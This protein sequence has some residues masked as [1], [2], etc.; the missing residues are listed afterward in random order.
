KYRLYTR[1][2]SLSPQS[3]GN[4]APQLV[5]L[6]SIWDPLDDSGSGSSGGEWHWWM[7]MVGDGGGE[8]GESLILYH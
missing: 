1:R 2:P 8:S 3:A 6:D 4:E 5:V 7:A